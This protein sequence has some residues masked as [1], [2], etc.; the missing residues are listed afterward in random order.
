MTIKWKPVALGCA[1]LGAILAI[2]GGRLDSAVGE[3][4]SRIA[5]PLILLPLVAVFAGAIRAGFLDVVQPIEDGLRTIEGG[6]GRHTRLFACALAVLLA[7]L[8]GYI[9]FGIAAHRE[10]EEKRDVCVRRQNVMLPPCT[11]Q[12]EAVCNAIH[13]AY[14]AKRC[15]T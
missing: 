12:D 8:G 2:L 11:G 4:L 6:N 15:G 13:S 10:A 9:Y 5:V 1:I 14:I 7:F 3:Q